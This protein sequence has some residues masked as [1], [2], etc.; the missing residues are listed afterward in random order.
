MDNLEELIG[1]MDACEIA[2]FI[3]R[4]QRQT[5]KETI[6]EI[7]TLIDKT[8]IKRGLDDFEALSAMCKTFIAENNNDK[9]KQI[10][11]EALE[12]FVNMHGFT[13]KRNNYDGEIEYSCNGYVID[14]AT[15]Q[16]LVQ[17]KKLIDC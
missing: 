7:K 15:M 13:L 16:I 5:R 1:S 17:A 6:E 3:I 9:Q 12:Y 4:V 10:L 2:E 11:K 14:E 8:H